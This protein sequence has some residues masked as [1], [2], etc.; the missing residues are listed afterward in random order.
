M[1][2]AYQW[3]CS[4]EKPEQVTVGDK[5]KLTCSGQSLPTLE[6]AVSLHFEKPEQDYTLA[7]LDTIR[8]ESNGGQFVVTGY[9]PGKY[10][11]VENIKLTD[12][13]RSVT[14]SPQSWEV[15]A[16]IPKDQQPPPEPFPAYGPFILSWPLW[17][18]MTIVLTIGAIIFLVYRF[19]KKRRDLAKLKERLQQHTSAL[20]AFG[21]FNKDI[22]ALTRKVSVGLK[23]KVDKEFVNELNQIFRYYFVREFW[24]PAQEWTSKET[25]KEI[26][27]T[28]AKLYQQ[29]K[30]ELVQVFREMDR[31][32]LSDGINGE[33]FEQLVNMSRDLIDGIY[34]LRSGKKK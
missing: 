12:G 4:I 10:D 31:A 13:K 33:D 5:F 21:Q 19:V 16:V 2:D 27:R 34:S 11:K 25:V 23:Q 30:P 24:I 22:R 7:V 9:K 29:F 8:V 1:S 20:G 3:T 6:G 15:I 17:L 32:V 28:H 18:W 14:I 26:K